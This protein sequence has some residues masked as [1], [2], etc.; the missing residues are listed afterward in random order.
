M[1]DDNEILATFDRWSDNADD[2]FTRQL[3]REAAVLIR[4]LQSELG[5]RVKA[6]EGAWAR[7]VLGQPEPESIRDRDARAIIAAVLA[8]CTS[9]EYDPVR[10]TL[11]MMGPE[12]IETT[13][14]SAWC[15]ALAAERARRNGGG[16]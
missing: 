13:M 9:A 12:P 10:R 16:K 1:M 2:L 4:R 8:S 7:G 14:I 6:H 3:A 5:D 15:D 11:S